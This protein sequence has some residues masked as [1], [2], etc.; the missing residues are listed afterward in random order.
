MIFQGVSFDFVYEFSLTTWALLATSSLLTVCTQTAKFK[1]FRY[2]EASQL[3][4]MAFLPNVWQFGIDL[5]IVQLTFSG[6]QYLG[7]ALLFAFY[8][9]EGIRF[10]HQQRKSR[11][12]ADDDF[13]VV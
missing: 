4:K 10:F 13:Q 8:V 5:V 12:V 7:F 11:Q 9:G 2:H 3:Q 6:M 1:A